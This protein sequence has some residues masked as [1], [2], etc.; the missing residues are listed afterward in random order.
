MESTLFRKCPH[1][2]WITLLSSRSTSFALDSESSSKKVTLWVSLIRFTRPVDWKL[3]AFENNYSVGDSRRL[4]GAAQVDF[5]KDEIGSFPV[6]HGCPDF[7][8]FVVKTTY[9]FYWH[10]TAHLVHVSVNRRW[11]STKSCKNGVPPTISLSIT[12]RNEPGDLSIEEAAKLAGDV[13]DL[14]QIVGDML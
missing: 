11:D 4:F 2:G 10:T 5:R 1:G 3:E 14:A 8:D 7:V 9:D 13:E 6:L 12:L